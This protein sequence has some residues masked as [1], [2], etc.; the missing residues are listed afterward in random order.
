MRDWETAQKIHIGAKL[1]D[2]PIDLSKAF[3]N[4]FWEKAPADLHKIV[5]WT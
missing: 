2:Q 3:T 4:G 5:S 1:I